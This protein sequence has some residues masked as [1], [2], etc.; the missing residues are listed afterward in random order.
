VLKPFP[1]TDVYP[2]LARLLDLMPE[3]NDGHIQD[4]YPALR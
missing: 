1:N 2:L 3:P 4:L